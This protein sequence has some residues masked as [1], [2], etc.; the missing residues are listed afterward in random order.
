MYM[1]VTDPAIS[2]DEALRILSKQDEILKSFTE[3]E[4]SVG[5]AGRALL[6][7][8]RLPS[9]DCRG[10]HPGLQRDSVRQVERGRVGDAH[11]IRG[12]V[13]AQR[14]TETAPRHARGAGDLTRI[15]VPRGIE[16]RCPARLVETERRDETRRPRGVGHSDRYRR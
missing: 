7:D 13:E 12:P 5:K 11:E 6:E 15:A 10:L 3:V 9:A 4:W 14:R 8:R 2:V 16:R 1:P